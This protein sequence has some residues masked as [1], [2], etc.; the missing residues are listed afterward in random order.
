ME[1]LVPNDITTT[2]EDGLFWLDVL[3]SP[4]THLGRGGGT[5]IKGG[6]E[7]WNLYPLLHCHHQNRLHSNRQRCKQG[8]CVAN[9]WQQSHRRVSIN[10]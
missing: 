8:Y 10:R 5:E 7:R 9:C 3:N 2:N 6:G 1:S 4:E